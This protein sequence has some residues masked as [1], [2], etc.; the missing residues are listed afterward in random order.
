MRSSLV[1]MRSSLERM[2]SS[3]VVRASDCQCTSCNGP[4]FDPSIRR[5]SGIW[6]AADEAVLN[7]V[8]NK[9]RK[10]SPKKIF[11]KKIYSMC[12][13]Y[14]FQIPG[15]AHPGSHHAATSTWPVAIPRPGSHQPPSVCPTHNAPGATC[16][17][18]LHLP[19]YP[20]TSR[21]PPATLG[22]SCSPC[23]WSYLVEQTSS[24]CPSHVPAATSHPPCVLP[25]M[26]LEPA[27]LS[28][29]LPGHPT[30]LQPPAGCLNWGMWRR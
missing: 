17:Y 2:R 21:Q 7:N 27:F 4:G 28:N 24:T 23:T 30:S 8:L 9:K 29:Q 10:K 19:V 5:H 15:N 11:K 18:K 26:H 25:T 6:G 1:R 16:L 3:L 14:Y 13:R 20:T 22:L 12:P